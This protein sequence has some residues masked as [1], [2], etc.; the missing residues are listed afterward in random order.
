[1]SGPGQF[2][3]RVGVS[4]NQAAL[5]SLGSCISFTEPVC[6]SSRS[7]RTSP[8]RHRSLSETPVLAQAWLASSP[9]SS[10]SEIVILFGVFFIVLTLLT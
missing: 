7:T 9:R 2:H 6:L 5:S 8:W 10:G 4:S 3:S 1:M